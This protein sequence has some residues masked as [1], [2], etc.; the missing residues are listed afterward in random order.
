MPDL[1]EKIIS[2]ALAREPGAEARRLIVAE[3]KKVE[4]LL[5]KRRLEGQERR[6]GR[7]R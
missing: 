3:E 5:T 2:R 1:I 6:P 4:R 7:V